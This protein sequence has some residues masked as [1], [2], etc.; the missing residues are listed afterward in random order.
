MLWVLEPVASAKLK[1]SLDP[2]VPHSDKELAEAFRQ[3]PWSDPEPL[4]DV[5]LGAAIVA[6]RET[7]GEPTS[8]KMMTI[9]DRAI[10]DAVTAGVKTAYEL[11]VTS[12]MASTERTTSLLAPAPTA[13]RTSR[14][15]AKKK[16]A[17]R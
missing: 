3:I 12:M 17:R 6:L 7:F 14:K 16:R 10:D 1:L 8:T 2:W 9:E 4:L 15:T 11:S 5:A 13:A